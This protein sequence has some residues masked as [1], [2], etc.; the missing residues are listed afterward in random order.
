MISTRCEFPSA[1]M[2]MTTLLRSPRRHRTAISRELISIIRIYTTTTIN[3]IS[4]N[5]TTFNHPHSL[6]AILPRI[7]IIICQCLH[8]IPRNCS[9]NERTSSSCSTIF[10]EHRSCRRIPTVYRHR[11]QVR[12]SKSSMN[13]SR[14][15]PPRSCRPSTR[16]P[17]RKFSHRCRSLSVER[18]VQ[19]YRTRRIRQL[20][21]HRDPI[22]F[23]N[24]FPRISRRINSKALT[25][26]LLMTC[27]SAMSQKPGSSPMMKSN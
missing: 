16:K 24:H 3:T 11:V 5:T 4:I 10:S 12:I 23:R 7:I 15:R 27:F 8:R 14:V 17:R 19:R 26:P 25:T 6:Q 1:K 22:P 2:T 9:K 13:S 20:R 21:F 18:R